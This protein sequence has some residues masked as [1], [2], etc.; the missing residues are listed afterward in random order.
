MAIKSAT[1]SQSPLTPSQTALLALF[2]LILLGTMLLSLPISRVPGATISVFD[3]FFTSTSAVCVTGLTVADTGTE[4]SF[5][6]TL[7]ILLLFQV[8]GLG[9]LL[10]SSTM[11]V[12]LGAHLGLRQ[13]LLMKE[14]LPGL[15]MS[16][17]GRL[18]LNV[19]GFALAVEVLGAIL[20]WLCW[21]HRV[22]G[23]AGLYQAFFHSA[24]AFCNAGFSLWPNSLAQ[25]VA[26]PVVNLV[27][28]A[29][30]SLGGLGYAVM[31]DVGRF[32]SGRHHRMSVHTRL[33]VVS[34]V[35]LMV[36]GILLFSLFESTQGG[37]LEQRSALERFLI[38][39]FQ[40]GSRTSGFST[41]NIGQLK[42]E[43]L[44][45]LMALMFIGGSPGS[46]A[47]GLKTTTLAI[48]VLAAWS[49]IR[50][51]EDVEIFGRRLAPALVFQALAMTVVAVLCLLT[52]AFILNAAEALPFSDVLF[53]TTSALGIVGLSTGVT[54]QLSDPSKGLI[55]LAMIVGRV[56]PLTLAM[57]LLRPR[58][59]LPIRHPSEEVLI[60]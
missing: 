23:L 15:S 2:G 14:Q 50:G 12:L 28:V 35:L 44:Q 30:A 42:P 5:F 16:G 10:W 13:R 26:H 31:R 9:M 41:I 27:I 58:R 47:G 24:S 3:A 6:G 34:S 52:F 51:R 49:Q 21:R 59:R 43:T 18:T 53:E 36:G 39:F 54:D 37:I 11:L 4:F 57:N 55:C 46:T 25:D 33:V 17:M 32:L 8:G 20:L 60:G 40:I 38:P 48:L 45:L 19:M 29:L 56:G 22:P 1:R 7:V